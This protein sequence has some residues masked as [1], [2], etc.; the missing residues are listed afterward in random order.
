MYTLVDRYS[1]IINRL[2]LL[3]KYVSQQ[4]RCG[5]QSNYCLLLSAYSFPVNMKSV[6]TLSGEPGFLR[7]HSSPEH[8]LWTCR[9]L[10]QSLHSQL[11]VALRH[12]I[13]GKV[14]ML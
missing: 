11:P 7:V 3:R 12:I 8:H 6:S 5:K 1:T 14:A 13:P 10:G 2:N 9:D 4:F